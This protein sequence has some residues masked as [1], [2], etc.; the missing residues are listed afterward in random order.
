MFQWFPGGFSQLQ[1]LAEDKLQ[2]VQ[3]FADVLTSGASAGAD[4]Q[5]MVICKQIASGAL[6]SDS[7]L[8]AVVTAAVCKAEKLL[9]CNWI[10]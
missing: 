9:D 4:Q 3:Q 1:D 10:C 2:Q 5:T 6:Q 8:K 7:V